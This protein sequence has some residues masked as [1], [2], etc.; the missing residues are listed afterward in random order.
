MSDLNVS[1]SRGPPLFKGDTQTRGP[2]ATWEFYKETTGFKQAADA[3]K[4]KVLD[5]KT[6]RVEQFLE[7]TIWC[8]KTRAETCLVP[9]NLLVRTF[10]AIGL[11]SID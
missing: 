11:V 3:L 1:T 8:E 7:T 2:W 10:D 9:Q 6:K 4:M 5:L